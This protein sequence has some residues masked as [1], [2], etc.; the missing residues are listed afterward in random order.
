VEIKS[1]KFLRLTEVQKRV[2]YSRSTIYAKIPRGEFPAP[3]ALGARAVAW[4]EGDIDKWMADRIALE[5][6]T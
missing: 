4:L 1:E 3:I 6:R 2:P 5:G